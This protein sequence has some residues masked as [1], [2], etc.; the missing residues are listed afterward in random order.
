MIDISTVISNRIA[1]FPMDTAFERDVLLDFERGSHITLSRVRTTV[2]L[3][4]HADAPIHYGKGGRTIDAQPLDLYVGPAHLV[5]VTGARGRAVTVADVAGKVPFGTE[6]VLIATET[7]PD[8]DTWNDD[9]ASID[10]ALVGWLAT[11]GVRLVAIDTPSVDQATSKDL[12]AHHAFFEHDVSIIEG[13]RLAGVAEGEYE[14]I[15]LPL[16][17]EGGDG[18]PLRAVLRPR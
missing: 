12:P 4:S 13:V 8:A 5:R 16:R 18:S 14:L 10:P 17:I 1:V 9:F 6:R 15:A 3:G 11:R 7:Y 2:H